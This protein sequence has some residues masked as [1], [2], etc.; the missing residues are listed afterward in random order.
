MVKSEK[1]LERA[2]EY[3]DGIENDRVGWKEK[4]RVWLFY[5]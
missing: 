2:V 3:R 5:L 1:V 4:D